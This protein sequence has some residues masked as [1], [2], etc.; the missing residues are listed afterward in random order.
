VAI[1]KED[2]VLLCQIAWKDAKI[3]VD[4][5]IECWYTLIFNPAFDKCKTVKNGITK[6]KAM[7]MCRAVWWDSWH[8]TW[9]SK[10]QHT[11]FSD[12]YSKRFEEVEKN[13]N[14][15]RDCNA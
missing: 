2:L 13:I 10:E 4:T 15:A 1:S 12:W 11:S 7:E 5:C 14:K 9:R 6:T 8:D 3:N